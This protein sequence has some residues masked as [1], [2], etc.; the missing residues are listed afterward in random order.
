MK[1]GLQTLGSHWW[2]NALG[3]I[4]PDEMLLH[5]YVAYLKNMFWVTFTDRFLAA[6]S[7]STDVMYC[8]TGAAVHVPDSQGHDFIHT[9]A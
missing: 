9:Y 1:T 2:F 5:I 4:N 8:R 7:W 3:Y 6:A